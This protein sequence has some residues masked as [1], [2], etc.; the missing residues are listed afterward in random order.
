LPVSITNDGVK[1]T[2][3]GT[4]RGVSNIDIVN[5]GTFELTG[6]GRSGNLGGKK[7]T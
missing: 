5:G 3:G 2:I 7:T 1:T 6:T 4:I